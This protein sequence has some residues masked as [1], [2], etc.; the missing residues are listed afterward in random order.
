[1]FRTGYDTANREI[2]SQ[3]SPENAQLV[4]LA[5]RADGKLVD[6]ITKGAKIHP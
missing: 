5:H 2:F 1:M 6:K 3:F 4:G